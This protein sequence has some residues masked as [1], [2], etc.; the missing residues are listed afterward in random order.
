MILN[1]VISNCH[2]DFIHVRRLLFQTEKSYDLT[3]ELNMWIRLLDDKRRW[4]ECKRY[5]AKLDWTHE[6]WYIEYF[7]NFPTSLRHII[8]SCLLWQCTVCTLKTHCLRGGFHLHSECKERI[9]L[10]SM[11]STVPY[12]GCKKSFLHRSM[13]LI[14][15]FHGSCFNPKFYIKCNG[16]NPIPI[17]NLALYRQKAIER[18]KTA[19]IFDPFVFVTNFI[20]VSKYFNIFGRNAWE[21]SSWQLLRKKNHSFSFDEN[22]RRRYHLVILPL[23]TW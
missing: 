23:C 21:L 5:C 12:T 7:V 11:H 14:R 22:I 6:Y 16:P 18:E 9:V 19:S 17:Q 2:L 4:C 10:T 15:D 1:M 3:L 13:S 20:V 8:P